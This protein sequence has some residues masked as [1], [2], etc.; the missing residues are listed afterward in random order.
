MW[1]R[2]LIAYRCPTGQTRTRSLRHLETFFRGPT[3]GGG[4]GS[5]PTGK[6]QGYCEGYS[7]ARNRRN[8]MHFGKQKRKVQKLCLYLPLRIAL[9]NHRGDTASP[10]IFQS[11]LCMGVHISQKHFS[12]GTPDRTSGTLLGKCFGGILFLNNR[13]KKLTRM[14]QRQKS[15]Q[16]GK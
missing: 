13:G 4:G 15:C 6:H 16:R 9:G 10:W 8:R 1:E 11:Y 2:S 14:S 5:A 7:G 12:T 3:G